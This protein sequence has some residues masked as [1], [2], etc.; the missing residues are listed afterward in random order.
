MVVGDLAWGLFVCKYMLTFIQV[1]PLFLD[2][3]TLDISA[4][5]RYGDRTFRRRSIRRQGQ[6]GDGRFGNGD[7]LA[8]GRFGDWY[9]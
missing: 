2:P 1:S 4:T 5:V 9:S 7:N 6:F 3:L 8:T